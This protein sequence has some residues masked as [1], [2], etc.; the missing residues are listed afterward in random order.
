M[1]V[2][3][4]HAPEIDLH[5]PGA[6]EPLHRFLDILRHAEV[7]A[8]EIV[9]SERDHS[10]RNA[11]AR[12][13]LD[14]GVLELNVARGDLPFP[15]LQG[16]LAAVLGS[17]RQSENIVTLTAPQFTLSFRRPRLFL[18]LDGE[19]KRVRTPLHFELLPGALTVLTAPAAPALSRSAPAVAEAASGS[20]T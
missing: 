17:W 14:G 18:S 11:G 13:D 3:L 12:E 19:V 5:L 4:P 1:E 8:E 15:L 6:G 10:E 7:V 2:A 9:G 16:G 20:A